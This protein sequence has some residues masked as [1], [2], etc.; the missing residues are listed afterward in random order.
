MSCRVCAEWGAP[1]AVSDTGRVSV[2]RQAKLWQWGAL[3]YTLI[4]SVF[5]AFM[6]LVAVPGGDGTRWVSA[7][8]LLSWGVFLPLLIPIALTLIPIVVRRWR[9]PVA[10][11]CTAVLGLTCALLALSWGLIFVPAPLIA[12]MGAYLTGRAPIEDVEVVDSPWKV[13]GA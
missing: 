1:A 5:F 12:A 11:T 9:V 13:P 6:P 10:W 8:A 2:A 4:A 7:F 3:V